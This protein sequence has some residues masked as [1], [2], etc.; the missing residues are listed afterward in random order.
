[1]GEIIADALSGELDVVLVRKLRA[2]G[3]PEFAIGS[4][5]ESGHIY[6]PDRA[7]LRSISDEYLT[8]ETQAQLNLI[9]K[10]RKHYTPIRMPVD[11]HNRI[12]VVVDD[13][14]ATGSTFIAA[15]RSVR[16]QKP[17]RLI[18]AIG[19][20]PRDTYELLKQEA[21]EVI[22]LIISDD[23]YSVSQFYENF[24]QTEDSEVIEILTRR[25]V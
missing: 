17:K 22:C 15:L 18:A 4:V 10:R 25:K 9:K 11:I 19:V 23:F 5:D 14:V 6:M 12:V 21:D 20:A 7:I 1:M 2:P 8:T 3:N 13:G 16:S 24:S